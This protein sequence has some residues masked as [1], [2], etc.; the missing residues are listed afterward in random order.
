MPRPNVTLTLGPDPV[1]YGA[2]LTA[3][4]TGWTRD[5]PAWS[6]LVGFAA[7][8]DEAKDLESYAIVKDG[9]ARFTI[10]PTPSWP[11]PSAGSGYVELGYWFRGTRFRVVADADFEVLA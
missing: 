7:D 8:G 5:E 10:G 4:V 6:H 3:T 1:Q 2:T 9:V 11:Q